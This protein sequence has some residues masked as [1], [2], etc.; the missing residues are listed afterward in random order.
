M[1]ICVDG[2]GQFD[3]SILQVSGVD[4]DVVPRLVRVLVADAAAD[5]PSAG[6]GNGIVRVVSILVRIFCSGRLRCQRPVSVRGVGRSST[7]K[8]VVSQFGP[9][10][11]PLALVTPTVFAHDED[12]DWW[13]RELSSVLLQVVVK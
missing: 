11:R 8:I 5:I 7:V 1:Q 2:T 12:S 3:R 6:G 10:Q 4:Q 9:L 13:P